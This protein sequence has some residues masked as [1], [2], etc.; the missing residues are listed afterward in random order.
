MKFHSVKLEL[1]NSFSQAQAASDAELTA[2]RQAIGTLESDVSTEKERGRGLSL[3][4]LEQKSLVATFQRDAHEKSEEIGRMSESLHRAEKQRQEARVAHA[5][6]LQD[7]DDEMNKV[8][9]SLQEETKRNAI[10]A[11]TIEVVFY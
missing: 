7:K 8:S 9:I 11:S 10:L 4:L 3:E 1:E 6:A 2:L 5:Q